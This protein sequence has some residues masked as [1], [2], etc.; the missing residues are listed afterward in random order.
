MPELHEPIREIEGLEVSPFH[1]AA[2]LAR[3]AS[4]SEYEAKLARLLEEEINASPRHSHSRA[5]P[6]R[7]RLRVLRTEFVPP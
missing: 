4:I 3:M 7:N 5:R 1:L 2:F 6:S